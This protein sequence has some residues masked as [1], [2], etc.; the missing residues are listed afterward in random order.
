MVRP[1]SPWTQGEC[2]CDSRALR[3]LRQV[4]QR[5]GQESCLDLVCH[6]GFSSFNCL[7]RM[8][9]FVRLALE[10][11][12]DILPMQGPLGV[13]PPEATGVSFLRWTFG[14]ESIIP[15]VRNP[16][17]TQFDFLVWH[18]QHRLPAFHPGLL[19]SRGCS[20]CSRASPVS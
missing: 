6:F 18:I 19:G 3:V 10:E 5:S 2:L 1:T 14:D 7:T 11:R 4:P 15:Q 16:W 9:G 17:P 20:S 12:R 8:P 13:L